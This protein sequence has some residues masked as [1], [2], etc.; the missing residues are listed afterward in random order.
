MA[1]PD[2]GRQRLS[3]PTAM[4]AVTVDRAVVGDA[5]ERDLSWLRRANALRDRRLR[6]NVVP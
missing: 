6:A 3:G 2:V 4:E 5:A 1:L